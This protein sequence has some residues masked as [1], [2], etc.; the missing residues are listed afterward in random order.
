MSAY[1][2][3]TPFYAAGVVNALLEAK[4]DS[5]RV[6]PQML[7]SYH[8][9]GT[10]ASATGPDDKKYFD[11]DAFK[12]WLDKYLAGDAQTTGRIDVKALAAEYAATT[13]DDDEDET[14]DETV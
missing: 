9:K 3:I 8:K 4:G 12:V 10:I 2:P 5:R 6:K 14:V 7:Y 13:E 1:A 11:G